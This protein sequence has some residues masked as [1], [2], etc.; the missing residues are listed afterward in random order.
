MVN[1]ARARYEKEV[2]RLTSEGKVQVMTVLFALMTLPLPRGVGQLE[3]LP[4]EDK[5][6]RM[7]MLVEECRHPLWSLK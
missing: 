3:G 5:K 7:K 2:S 6:D 1:A 4:S